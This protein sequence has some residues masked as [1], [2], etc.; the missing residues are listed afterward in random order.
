[1]PRKGGGERSRREEGQVRQ[2][3]DT[4]PAGSNHTKKTI[5]QVKVW[6]RV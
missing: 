6:N 3:G 1:M 4:P 2:P 5:V